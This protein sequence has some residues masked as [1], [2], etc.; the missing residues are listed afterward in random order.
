MLSFLDFEKPV[1]DLQGKVHE[2]K[3]VAGTGETVEVSQEIARLEQKAEQT[4]KELYAKLTPWQKTQV[5]RHPDRPHAVDYIS[6]LIEDFT[7]LSGDRSYAEDA[8]IIAGI[9]RFRG[10]S[11]AILGQEK[12]ADTQSR[13][14]RNFGMAR[15]EGYRKAV[16]IMDMAERFSLP[17][18]S[19]VDTA[20]AYPGIG[21][22]ERGQAEAIARSTDAGL[23]LS[24]A[25]V[26]LII[27][28]GGSGGAIAIAT[29]N[30]VAMLEHSIY[31][32]ISPE[33][34]ASILWR[35]SAR[36]QDAATNMKITAQDL[37]GL[38]VIDEIIEE[39]LGGAHRA[40]E[41][42][43]DRAGTAIEAALARFDGMSA[44]EIRAQRRAKFLEIGRTL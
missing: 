25:S 24:T 39:P 8:A 1:A 41:I 14:K 20:G 34:G 28:E 7:P 30:H 38:R 21:A 5:A 11:V 33:A 32:V 37:I 13:L 35:D 40:K 3:A 15:P 44:E 19:L 12:G 6:G 27:G 17:V 29:A 2:L 42:V 36:A 10:R 9:G 22:E 26:A 4:L 18:V 31:S 43:V 16:R 23:G